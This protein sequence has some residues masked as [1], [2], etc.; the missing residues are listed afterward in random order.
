MVYSPKRGNYKKK[1]TKQKK[2]YLLPE[3][4]Y[5]T[6]IPEQGLLKFIK[7]MFGKTY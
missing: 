7:L 5:L 1:K 6:Q 2:N 4:N 3:G